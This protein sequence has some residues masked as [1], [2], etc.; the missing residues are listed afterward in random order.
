M[1]IETRG[2]KVGN[3]NICGVYGSLTEDHIPPKGVLRP[4][5]VEIM[6][7]GDLMS[8]PR[9]TKTSRTSQNGVKY[10]T[11]CS[12]CN[13]RLLGSKYDPTLIKFAN[14]IKMFLTSS[15]H[16]P[17]STLLQVKSGR[18]IRSVIGHLLAHGVGEHRTG[19]MITDLTDYF[20]DETAVFPK[21]IKLYYWVY[22]YP[23]QI[24][25][26]GFSASLDYWN[27][28]AVCMLLKFFPVSFFFVV[29][30][31]FG[32]TLPIDRL[33][34]GTPQSIDEEVRI[35]LQFTSIPAQR[36]PEF[37]GET[38]MVMHTPGAT[39]AIPKK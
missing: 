19:T 28:F 6:Q 24:I 17:S 18:L 30:E 32:W 22:P 23:E 39:A 8:I 34:L 35:R 16:L 25:L 4:K 31:P 10:R 13:N 21:N 3:C 7:L 33:D 15:F 36:W 2:S 26:K 38:G 37:P 9:P 14:E 1:R 12:D 5:Q 20:L 29:D 11:L 27:S